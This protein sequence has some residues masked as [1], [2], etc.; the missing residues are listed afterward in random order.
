MKERVPNP[1]RGFSSVTTEGDEMEMPAPV[2]SN[3]SLGHGTE[4]NQT[5]DPSK[6]LEESATLKS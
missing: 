1:P 3:Q 6:K 2:V 5:P 4:K